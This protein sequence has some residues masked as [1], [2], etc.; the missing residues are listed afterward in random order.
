MP[1]PASS[2]DLTLTEQGTHATVTFRLDEDHSNAGCTQRPPDPA[3]G[4]RLAVSQGRLS[5]AASGREIL[6][7]LGGSRRRL[8]VPLRNPRRPGCV[9]LVAVTPVRPHLLA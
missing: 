7:S 9:S 2:I 8:S 6:G 5:A 1:G 4:T 3:P